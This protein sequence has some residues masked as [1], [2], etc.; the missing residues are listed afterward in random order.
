[1]MNEERI[2]LL[3]DQLGMTKEKLIE[4]IDS[5]KLVYGNIMIAM[6][7]FTMSFKDFF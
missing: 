4:I 1:M 6:E 5:F 7:N 3:A 2:V